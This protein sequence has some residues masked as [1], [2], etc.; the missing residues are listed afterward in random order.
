MKPSTPLFRVIRPSQP[1]KE[2]AKTDELL[3]RHVDNLRVLFKL[4]LQFA[5]AIL[6][7]TEASAR[8]AKATADPT[9]RRLP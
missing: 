4:D 2:S 9:R 1:N 5:K 8:R 7:S 6:R 3:R